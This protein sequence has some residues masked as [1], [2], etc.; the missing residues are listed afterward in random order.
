M[1]D[2]EH[3]A[4]NAWKTPVLSQYRESHAYNDF[5]RMCLTFMCVPV[6]FEVPADLERQIFADYTYLRKQYKNKGEAL[7]NE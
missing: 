5:R 6:D 1:A 7:G 2:V 4:S 3:T